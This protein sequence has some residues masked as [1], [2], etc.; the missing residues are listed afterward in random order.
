VFCLRDPL[1]SFA[2]VALL[3]YL[4]TKKY[5]VKSAAKSETQ[6]A[7]DRTG[8]DLPAGRSAE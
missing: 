7:D 2:E 4:I 5:F 3:P 6:A 8:A 1:P